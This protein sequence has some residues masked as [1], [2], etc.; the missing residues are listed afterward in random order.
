VADAQPVAP[1]SGFGVEEVSGRDV[2]LL[3]A[4]VLRPGLPLEDS[5]YAEDEA[6]GTHHL[7]VR[8]GDGRVVGVATYFP[9]PWPDDRP[10]VDGPAWR[11]RGMAAVPEVRGTGVGGQLLQAGIDLVGVLDGRLLWCN[12]RTV[13]LGFY[14]RYGFQIDPEEFVSGPQQVLHHRAW[15][16]V[17]DAERTVAARP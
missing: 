13:A 14:T 17:G 7:A 1:G 15:R 4:E 16:P 11:L 9:D 10:P 6:A 5:V 3:R 12:A 8:L 2:M